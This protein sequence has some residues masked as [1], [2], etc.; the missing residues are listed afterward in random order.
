MMWAKVAERSL[1]Q[2][3]KT[4]SKSKCQPAG[5]RKPVDTNPHGKK[6]ARA[7]PRPCGSSPHTPAL[8]GT[9]ARTPAQ[10]EGGSGH[11]KGDFSRGR[12]AYFRKDSRDSNF[13]KKLKFGQKLFPTP[14]QHQDRPKIVQ[15]DGLK[16]SRGKEKGFILTPKGTRLGPFSLE[17]PEHVSHMRPCVNL[18]IH[19]CGWE[20][21]GRESPTRV[22]PLSPWGNQILIPLSLLKTWR[23]LFPLEDHMRIRKN[24]PRSIWVSVLV[25]VEDTAKKED[26]SH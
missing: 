2:R 24:G 22:R 18:L 20:K 26:H 1:S 7:C 19:T 9:R 13:K 3:H 17:E 12:E 16:D 23:D 4:H 8:E 6:P 5:G 14:A 11:R 25:I 21:E 10:Q 15:E